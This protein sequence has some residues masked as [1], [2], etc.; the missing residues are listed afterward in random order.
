M[1][2]SD[3]IKIFAAF[4]NSHFCDR[5]GAE[6]FAN[7]HIESPEKNGVDICQ[8]CAILWEKEKNEKNYRY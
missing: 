4:N 3:Y 1:V 6:M 8:K 7:M 2:K 5:C